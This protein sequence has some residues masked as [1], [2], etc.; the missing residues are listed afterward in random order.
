MFIKKFQIQNFKSFQDITIH[1]N[2]DVNILTGRNNTGKTTA[3]E[4]FS[5][6][7]EC[8]QKLLTQ[9]KRSQRNYRKGDWVLGPTSNRYFPFDQINSVRSPNFEDL[10]HDCQKKN[11]IKLSVV[12]EDG[13]QGT[14]DIRF[15]IGESGNNYLIELDGFTTFNFEKFNFFLPG[16]PDPFSIYYASPIA[17][18]SSV[19][20][21]TTLSHI[22]K[23][24]MTQKSGSVLRNRLFYIYRFPNTFDLFQRDLS[25]ILFNHE[26]SIL[27]EIVFD[28]TKD[29][30]IVVKYKIESS[31][32]FKDIALLGSGT[33]QL[34]E[35][36]LNFYQ[37]DSQ[38]KDFRLIMLDEPDSY[39][40][41]D[42]QKR[43]VEI[44]T[45][46]A[47]NTQ[48]IISTHNESFIRSAPIEQIFHLD[49]RKKGE[50]MPIDRAEIEKLQPRFKGIYP[51]LIN[52]VIR[53][54]GEIT[55][56]DFINAMECDRL[57]FVE[58]EDD[59][60]VLNVLLK[61]RVG[62]SKRYMF[63]V[64]GGINEVFEN[65]LAYK[66]VF[67]SI[68]NGRDLWQKSCVVIDKDFLTHE[69]QSAIIS[70]FKEKYQL[71]VFS[72]EAYTF[73]STTF[74]NLEFL[75]VLM[76]KWIESNHQV[77]IDR[78]ELLILLEAEYAKVHQ[79]LEGRYSDNFIEQEAQRYRNIREKTNTLFGNSS[80]IKQNDIA[81]PTLVRTNLKHTLQTNNYYWL[82][83]KA[84]VEAVMNPIAQKYGLNFTCKTDFIEIIK[85]VTKSTWMSQWN[86]LNQ[87]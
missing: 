1:L 8:F 49:G 18:V 45:R 85:A 35:I 6:W 70:K 28:E 79:L 32:R 12:L 47:Q 60:R 52:P 27:F 73:E 69:H 44:V 78:N 7:Y 80:V 81:L 16:L 26:K 38:G 13:A 43:L 17:T 2:R 56:L 84:E 19:E 40:H 64:L 65:I 74:E 9:A 22:E 41:R 62:V 15:N 66:T 20:D 53:A 63:W 83:R 51:S 87:L 23:A 10:F 5:L 58:G 55:G 77:S 33:L 11:K 21:Y 86:F 4:A 42:I 24:C 36:L 3:L 34:I 68:K 54:V 14:L 72:C 71:D 76:S 39:I 29:T 67:S 37:A 48:V 50:Y 57:I 25:Y 61:Q 30:R 59:A 82:M 75:S 31:E 46:F